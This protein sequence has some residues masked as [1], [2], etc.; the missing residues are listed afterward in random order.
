MLFEIGKK[1]LCRAPLPPP[2]AVMA[3]VAEL[4]SLAYTVAKVM[5][6][7]DDDE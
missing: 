2:L 6:D 4:A 7:D 5:A 1:L 3:T